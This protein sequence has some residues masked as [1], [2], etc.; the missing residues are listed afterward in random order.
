MA[1]T[2]VDRTLGELVAERPDRARVFER[3]GLDY[4]CKGRRRLVD[5]AAE[6]GLDPAGVAAQLDLPDGGGEPRPDTAWTPVELIDHILATHHAYLHEEL[7]LLVA[8]A[9]KVRDAHQANHPELVEVAALVQELRADLEPHLA[10]EEQ[11]L[12]PAARRLEDG[13]TSFPFGSFADP[14]GTMLAEHDRAGELLA[15]LRDSTND[16]EAPAD[17]CNSYRSLYA[18]LAEL[19]A[20]THR[21]VHLENNVLFPALLD[22]IA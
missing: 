1:L 13:A 6:V 16:Y 17:A 18:R 3:L 5:A 15:T 9:D 8:L 2:D 7:P 10:K 11:V 14:I 22:R 4:C 20:D 21:H 12:F 19:E